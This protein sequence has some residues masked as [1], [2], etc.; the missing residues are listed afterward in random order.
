[1][2]TVPLDLVEIRYENAFGKSQS[3]IST[4]LVAE[5]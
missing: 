3:S 5:V 4:M 1:M 2:Y